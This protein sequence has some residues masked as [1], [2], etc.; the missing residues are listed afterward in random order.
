MTRPLFQGVLTALVT[1]FREGVFDPKAF[2]DLVERQIDAGVDGVV[3]MGTTGEASTVSVA[4]HHRVVELCVEVVNGRA[5]VIAG[6]GGNDTA[7]VIE[8]VRHAKGAGADAALVVTPYY[9]RPSQEGLYRHYAAIDAAVDLPVILYNVPGRTG[10]DLSN[11][12]VARL[13]GLTHVKGIKDATADMT[14]AGLMRRLVPHDFAMISGD[15]GSFLGYVACGGVGCISV[16]ANVAPEAMVALW[17]AAQ[18]GDFKGALDWQDRLIR[19][20]KGLFLDASPTPTKYAL[21]RL[22][23]CS[24]EVRLPLA[25]CM[26]AVKPQIDDAMRDAGL[27]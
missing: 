7:K 1:P 13:A 21:N 9:N 26:D 12:T 17:R 18:S 3:P 23:L 20:H 15:D 10:V 27:M 8:L 4:E 5:K 6:C 11:E 16:T 22:N 14:R 2:A 19:L 24:E 25:P